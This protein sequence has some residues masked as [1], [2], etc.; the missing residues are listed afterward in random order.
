VGDIVRICPECEQE[1]EWLL[2]TGIFGECHYICKDCKDKI[3]EL[4]DIDNMSYETRYYFDNGI[5]Q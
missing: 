3:R 1:V 5:R 2:P 4:A